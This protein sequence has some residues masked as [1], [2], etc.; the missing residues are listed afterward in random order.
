MLEKHFQVEIAA[1][2]AMSRPL[3]AC[4]EEKVFHYSGKA[5]GVRDKILWVPE[6]ISWTL[7]VGK[8]TQKQSELCRKQPMCL[9]VSPGLIGEEFKKA[10]DKALLDACLAWNQLDGTAKFRIKLPDVEECSA[11]HL[12]KDQCDIDCAGL[13]SDSESDAGSDAEADD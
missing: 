5:L 6:S 13:K 8:E 10:R 1:I 3:I 12:A 7:K 9:D 11:I 4:G 2:K